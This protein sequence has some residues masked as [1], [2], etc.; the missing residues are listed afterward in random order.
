MIGKKSIVGG[1]KMENKKSLQKS[2]S[3]GSIKQSIYWIGVP[4]QKWKSSC[5]KRGNWEKTSINN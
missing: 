4:S 5:E 1:K 3:N 2:L